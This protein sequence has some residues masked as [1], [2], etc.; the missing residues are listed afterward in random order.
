MHRNR[1]QDF[2]PSYRYK[3]LNFKNN[4]WFKMYVKDFLIFNM[5]FKNCV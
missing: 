3:I 4:T 5:Y 1:T 2:E